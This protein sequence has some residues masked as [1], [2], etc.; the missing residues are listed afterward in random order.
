MNTRSRAVSKKKI[1]VTAADVKKLNAKRKR[2]DCCQTPKRNNPPSQVVPSR[3]P[4]PVVHSRNT[5]DGPNLPLRKTKTFYSVTK[6]KVIF[7]FRSGAPNYVNMVPQISKQI[8]SNFN[9]EYKLRPSTLRRSIHARGNTPPPE[10]ISAIIDDISIS[11]YV[12]CYVEDYM[13]SA[14]GDRLLVLLPERYQSDSFSQWNAMM[15][16]NLKSIELVFSKRKYLGYVAVVTTNPILAQVQNGMHHS[17]YSAGFGNHNYGCNLKFGNE[18]NEIYNSLITWTEVLNGKMD[19]LQIWRIGGTFRNVYQNF[20]DRRKTNEGIIAVLNTLFQEVYGD[21]IQCMH[22]IH[23]YY[24]STI[25]SQQKYINEIEIIN[26]A[27]TPI[28]LSGPAYDEL[29]ITCDKAF[30]TAI[31]STYTNYVMIG[32]PIM[33]RDKI[34]SLVSLYMTSLPSHYATFFELLGFK[35]KSKLTKN[36]HLQQTGYYNRQVFYNMLAMARQ[37]NPQRMKNWAMISSGANYG[38]GIGE[39]VNRRSTYLGAS[40]TTQTFLKTVRPYGDQM[41]ERVTRTLSKCKKTVWMLD[42]NQRGHPLKF[43]RFGSS[44]TFVKVTGRT[45]RKCTECEIYIGEVNGEDGEHIDSMDLA[46]K[47]ANPGTCTTDSS[48]PRCTLSTSRSVPTRNTG[49]H[50][51]GSIRIV[52]T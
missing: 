47:D 26:K 36:L 12:R 35:L 21:R 4:S 39:I 41:I 18:S 38:R 6:D 51:D 5:I 46:F 22:L 40:T 52:K 49:G 50:T 11:N 1:R 43:Q 2:E 24:R 29:L 28:E 8:H 48:V 27:R 15:T 19:G 33:S 34:M 45:S 25:I 17:D 42:N 14:I 10:P 31:E 23:C 9:Y 32:A 37:K 20:C 7:S 16:S 44:N 3:N 13:T 30:A